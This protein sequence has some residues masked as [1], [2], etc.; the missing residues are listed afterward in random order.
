MALLEVR[1]RIITRL[2]FVAGTDRTLQIVTDA[3]K[4]DPATPTVTQA[5]DSI[6]AADNAGFA[7]ADVADIFAGF[8]AMGLGFDSSAISSTQFP[9]SIVESFFTPNLLLGAVTFS[10][11]AKHDT[12]PAV[13]ELLRQVLREPLLP[14]DR[15]SVV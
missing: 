7:G 11:Q 5:R 12:L 3:M 1:A 8:A 10:I 6:I 2:G 15:K 4:L 14:A 9:A 13:L